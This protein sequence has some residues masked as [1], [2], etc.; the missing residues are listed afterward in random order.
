MI[1]MDS[2]AY[3]KTTLL[4][5]SEDPTTVN[6]AVSEFKRLTQI[7]ISNGNGTYGS[8]DASESYPRMWIRIGSKTP[9]DASASWGAWVPM[10]PGP[11]VFSSSADVTE[12]AMKD[13]LRSGSPVVVVSGADTVTRTVTLP[14]PDNYAG[15]KFQIEA[16]GCQIKIQYKK[17]E[18]TYTYINS[19][20]KESP[21]RMLYPVECDGTNWYVVTVS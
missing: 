3:A 16:V 9:S 5:A 20:T 14:P 7:L 19:T 18:T 12:T 2:D 11:T 6:E 21:N 8:V 4:P 15:T 13:Y 10:Q 17:G 1:V